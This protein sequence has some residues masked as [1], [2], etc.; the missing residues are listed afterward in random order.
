MSHVRQEGAAKWIADWITRLMDW[1]IT[2]LDQWTEL[3]D[4]TDGLNYWTGLICSYHI[5]SSQSVHNI[6][7]ARVVVTSNKKHSIDKV[8]MDMFAF[9]LF[10][11]HHAGQNS[12]KLS[13]KIHY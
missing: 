11:S 10:G 6:P 3:L 8:T 2:G 1:P 7:R 13:H 9:R 4:W 5:T 12:L